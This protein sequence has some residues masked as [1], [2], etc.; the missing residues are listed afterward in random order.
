[1]APDQANARRYLARLRSWVRRDQAGQDVR[2]ATSEEPDA[3]AAALA[4]FRLA[5]EPAILVTVAMAYEGLDAPET[6]VV[7]ALTGIRSRPWLEQMIARATRVDPYAGPYAGQRALVFDPDDPMFRRFRERIETE[8]GTLARQPL[9]RRQ[10]ALDFGMA[11]DERGRPILPL[12]SNATGLR[13]MDLAPGPDSA[14]ARPE[15]AQRD[16]LEVP[17]LRERDLRRRV[18]QAVAGQVVEDEMALRIPRASGGHHAYAAALKRLM[19]EAGAEDVAGG[20]GSDAGLAGA[21]PPLRPSPFVGRRCALRL[22]AA[23]AAPRPGGAWR[24]VAAGHRLSLP[25]SQR[26][27]RHGDPDRAEPG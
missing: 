17:S 5:A 12:A 2:I 14:A 27:G 21:Q 13:Y 1:M 19:V 11:L 4:A 7:A 22:D 18:G 16:L 8:Q 25:S 3:Q 20:T 24:A 10:R 23:P 15:H 9:P 6:A 26:G